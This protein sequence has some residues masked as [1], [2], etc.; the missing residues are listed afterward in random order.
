ML[1]TSGCSNWQNGSCNTAIPCHVTRHIHIMAIH[2]Y[3]QIQ[4]QLSCT[5]YLMLLSRYH[6]WMLICIHSI[7]H[8]FLNPVFMISFFV[9]CPSCWV[10]MLRTF[11]FTSDASLAWRVSAVMLSLFVLFQLYG[12]SRL[13]LNASLIHSSSVD[14]Y[15]L[16]TPPYS[17]CICT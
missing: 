12:S 1:T 7:H 2:V 10:F 17:N 16:Y 15:L 6:V 5:K 8:L 4:N 14:L 13:S 3:S 11:F 9:S